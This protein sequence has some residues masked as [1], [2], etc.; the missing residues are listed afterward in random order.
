MEPELGRVEPINY[1]RHVAPIITN[2][3]VP[4]HGGNP[5]APT[6]TARYGDLYN[7]AF[8]FAGDANGSLEPVHGGSRSKPGMIGAR[9]SRMGKALLNDTHQKA[10]VEGKYTEAEVRT[11]FQWLDLGSDELGSYDN[12]A[13]QRKGELVW[14]SL[15]FDKDDPQGLKYKPESP[16]IEQKD[17]GASEP[18]VPA[19]NVPQADAA[20]AS[21]DG[22]A[23][24]G[25]AGST[26]TSVGGGTA[27][28]SG[29]VVRGGQSGSQTPGGTGG[30]GGTGPSG[31]AGGTQ[32]ASTA[33]TVVEGGQ[34]GARG[35][36]TTQV[37]AGG[38]GA[39]GSVSQKTKLGGATGCK[40]NLGANTDE[41][42][43]PWPLL[44]I[45]LALLGRRR[46]A[47]M[48]SL[49]DPGHRRS[50]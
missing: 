2:K 36:H 45:G 34:S 50:P 49:G 23:G 42:P 17:A 19:A 16:L 44:V 21:D 33:S 13:A 22:A 3:C 24:G 4:C 10:Q 35:S 48:G 6:F 15:D 26:G 20:R 11:L 1:N 18:D 47:A 40:C 28:S 12:P 9:G 7:Y 41:P 43:S 14:P 39:A 38:G 32:P 30:S 5:K 37:S 25:I 27:G 46:R 31:G 8:W 29:T